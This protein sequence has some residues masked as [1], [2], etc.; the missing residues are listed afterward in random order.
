MAVDENF[1][2]HAVV[3]VDVLANNEDE[4]VLGAGQVFPVPVESSDP[5]RLQSLWIITE[6]DFI[7][8]TIST[9]GMLP[10]LLQVDHHTDVQTKV[11]KRVI[12]KDRP[13]IVAFTYSSI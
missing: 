13:C 6:A 10:R 12:V 2:A 8:D 1:L 11:T 7:V 4:L 9:K 5:M 3:S